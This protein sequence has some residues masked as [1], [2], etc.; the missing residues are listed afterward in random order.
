MSGDHRINPVL[1]IEYEHLN[2]ADKTFKEVV[3]FDGKDDF[4]TPNN[5]AREETAHE[6]ETRLI[7]SSEIRDWNLSENFVAEKNIHEGKW[8]FGYAVGVSR[9]LKLSSS[10]NRCVFCRENLT[11]GAEFYGGLGIWGDVTL[12]GTSQY[13][14]PVLKWHLPSDTTIRVSPGWGLTDESLGTPFRFGVSQEIDGFGSWI[15]KLFRRH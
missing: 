6:F 3:G 15:T 8:E 2:G 9:P 1:Y 10:G 7:L 11:A 14:A 4:S 5:E 13:I 12:R